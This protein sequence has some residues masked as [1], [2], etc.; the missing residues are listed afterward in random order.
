MAET[1][2]TV[3]VVLAEKVLSSLHLWNLHKNIRDG[4]E[5]LKIC[6]RTMQAYLQGTEGNESQK[7]R[8]EQVRVVAYDI[9]NVLDELMRHAPRR[10]RRHDVLNKPRQTLHDA[11]HW[12]LVHEM[13]SKMNDIKTKIDEIKFLD[14]FREGSG[15]VSFSEEGSSSASSVE[16]QI[17]PA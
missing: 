7:E 17:K 9:E 16:H 13:P 11:A 1:A 14:S 12:F 10:F 4:V 5:H 15:R 6:L 8:R 2:V 3:S